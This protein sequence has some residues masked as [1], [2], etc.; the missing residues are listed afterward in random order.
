M[1]IPFQI[2]FAVII[3]SILLS[4]IFYILSLHFKNES[5]KK[6]EEQFKIFYNQVQN[7]CWSFPYTQTKEKLIVNQNLFAIFAIDDIE[8][9]SRDLIE[10][11]INNK[12]LT[13]G[14]FLCLWMKDKRVYCERLSCNISIPIVYYD[15]TKVI[16]RDFFGINEYSIYF[17]L[18]R[19]SN[20]V[21]TQ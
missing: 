8:K 12:N 4:S 20:N 6:V 16:K 3:L 7:L 9:I 17:D 19:Y 10:E 13:V 14:N 18:I 15:E 1:E 2:I 11:Y 21:S 5:N